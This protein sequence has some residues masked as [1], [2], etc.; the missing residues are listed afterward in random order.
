VDKKGE[1]VVLLDIRGVADIADYFV[2]CSGTSRRML[3]ALV[4]SVKDAIRSEYEIRTKIEGE[5]EGGWMLADYGDVVVHFFSPEQRK[6]YDLEEL[7]SGG[8]VLVHMQ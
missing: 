3:Q 1:D 5:S 8:K 2:I 7:W 6:F 4:K